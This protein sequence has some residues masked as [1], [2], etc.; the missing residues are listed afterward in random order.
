MLKIAD[1]D[2]Q[3]TNQWLPRAGLGEMLTIKGASNISSLLNI[4]KIY[5]DTIHKSEYIYQN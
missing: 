3:K 1:L 4:L 5:R 2:W